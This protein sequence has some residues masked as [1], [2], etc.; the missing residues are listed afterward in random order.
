M[1][2]DGRSTASS[3]SLKILS[4]IVVLFLVSMIVF[5][6][7]TTTTE[8]EDGTGVGVKAVRPRIT[9]VELE[10]NFGT[11]HLTVHIFDLNSWRHV[12]QVSVEFYRGDERIRLY[13]FNQTQD[14]ERSITVL[15]GDGLVDFESLSS[16][17]RE[18]VDQRCTLTLHFQFRATNYD[19]LVIQAKDHAGGTSESSI[20]FHG[21]TT[22]RTVTWFLLPLILLVT[23]ALVYKMWKDTGGEIDEE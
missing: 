16:E 2:M 17:E 22:G 5:P 8:A 11:H 13:I 7:S 15:D 6:F 20:R 23:V 4:F 1:E 18:T 19:R 10:H 3:A 12:S 21:I 9:E 14:L